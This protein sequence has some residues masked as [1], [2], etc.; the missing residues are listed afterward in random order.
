MK[1]YKV[2]TTHQ[3]KLFSFNV[4]CL[5]QDFNDGFRSLKYKLNKWTEPTIEGSLLYAFRTL[6]SAKTFHENYPY[7]DD[8][9]YECEATGIKTPGKYMG[10]VFSDKPGTVERFWNSRRD[11]SYCFTKEQAP[12]T[13]WCASIKPLRRIE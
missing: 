7:N 3:G 1:V 5:A 12:G 4:G 2:F 6:K 13:V 8:C 10:V 11:A 9:I